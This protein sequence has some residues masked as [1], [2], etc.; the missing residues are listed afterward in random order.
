MNEGMLKP[1]A[2]RLILVRELS[3]G[4]KS[5]M[6]LRVAYFGVGRAEGNT[7]NT[8]FY[9][10]LKAACSEKLVKKDSVGIYSLDVEGD[11]MLAF[12]REQ[13]MDLTVI[14]SEA[15]TRW[16]MEHPQA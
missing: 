14:K 15:Q 12:A 16:E 7:A 2:A 4:P 13:K 5:H 8:S 11:K 10:K 9:N 3:E 1:S 6:A